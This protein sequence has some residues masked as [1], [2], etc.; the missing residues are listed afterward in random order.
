MKSPEE[1]IAAVKSYTEGKATMRELAE[2]YQVHHSSIEKWLHLYQTFGEK[3]L[4]HPE[5][6]KRYS[7][8][9]KEAAVRSYLS[10]GHPMYEVCDEYKIRSVS[11]LQNWIAKYEKDH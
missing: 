11:L 3:G 5:H 1:K 10:G 8:E 6:N 9:M 4:C 7:E 2:K